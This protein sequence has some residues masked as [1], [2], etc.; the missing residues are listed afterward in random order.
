MSHES[1][2]ISL[3]APKPEPPRIPP[4]IMPEKK[5]SRAW[6]YV[7]AAFIAIALGWG[8]I[9]F[10]LLPGTRGGMA[11]TT[12]A[13]VDTKKDQV[14]KEASDLV[15]EVGSLIILP[16]G[17]TPTIATVSDPS[18]LKDQRFFQNAKV[19]D[20]VLIYTQASQAYLYRPSAHLLVEVAPITTDVQKQ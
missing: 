9:Q 1:H 10:N 14:Q 13:T 6:I 15:A 17:E 18:K 19:G 16:Y 3:R 4:P 20:K 12:S 7:V 5:R 8:F 2:V 11:T